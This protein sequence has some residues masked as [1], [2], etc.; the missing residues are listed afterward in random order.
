MD[1]GRRRDE[2]FRQQGITFA[3]SD[4][5]GA[6]QD[7]PFPLDLVPRIIPA[8]EW[9]AIERGLIQR[10]RALNA[11][12]DDVYH[13]REII[14]EGIVPWE[15]VLGSPDFRRAVHGVRPPGG[16]CHVAGFDL[17]R[18]GDGRSGCSRTTSARPSG[19]SY[20]V[21]NRLAMTRLVPE[22]FAR[23][24][25]RPVDQYPQLL[26][27]ALREFAPAPGREPD[28][29]RAHPRPANNAYFEHS[30]LARQMGVELVEGRD[31]VVRDD[32]CLHAHDRGAGAGR[33]D[34]PAPRRRLPRPARV[35]ARLAARRARA[36]SRASAPARSRSRTRS[37]P[38]WPTTR[39]STR[40]VPEMVRY[41]LGEEPILPTSRPTCSRTPSSS[42][43]ALDRLDELVVKPVDGSGGYGLVIGPHASDEELAAPARAD[44]RRSPQPGSRRRS[45]SSRPRRRRRRRR[46]PPSPCRPA[47]V[48]CLGSEIE[49]CPAG[50]PGWRSARALIVNS[51]PGRRV[52]GHLG[53]RPA[54]RPARA[55]RPTRGS[56]PSCRTHRARSRRDRMSNSNNSNAGRRRAEPPGRVATTLL[57][58]P[59][60]RTRRRH[61][62]DPRRPLPRQPAVA[63]RPGRSGTP[64]GGGDDRARRDP[65]PGALRFA[66]AR[67]SACSRSTR[68]AR[69]R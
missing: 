20:V 56:C 3:I 58:R 24:R 57:D 43:A 36:S 59:V 21:E 67:R 7:R 27:R 51:S 64:L 50:S 66:P 34:L 10:I 44:R 46:A 68:R 19:I 29:G 6:A 61:R 38:A 48:R 40:Y 35:P 1:L 4:P 11:F 16:C 22:L 8:H 54:R 62:A 2:T 52:E 53:A 60:R 18:G 25:V 42:S 32:I 15:L 37:A 17:V 23:H 45:C 28:R 26:L 30:F 41:Y 33:R 47:P 39:P 69:P 31:L 65:D 12:L 14:R 13:G 55:G 5:S 63:G 9:E 49:S